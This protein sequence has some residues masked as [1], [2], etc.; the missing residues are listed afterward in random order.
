M[1]SSPISSIS[2]PMIML[3]MSSASMYVLLLPADQGWN[4][5]LVT[6]AQVAIA[7]L[8][9]CRSHNP[10]VMSSILTCH[11]WPIVPRVDTY[12]CKPFAPVAA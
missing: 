10:K 1:G 5:L 11:V 6:A 3:A 2:P 7:Q 8:A 12:I 4:M 9:P